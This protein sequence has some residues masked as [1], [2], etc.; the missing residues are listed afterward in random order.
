MILYLRTD[1]CTD[2]LLIGGSIG[3]TM[4]VVRELVLQNGVFVCSSA[5]KQ[6]FKKNN[7][8]FKALKI[9]PVFSVMR[10]KF[11][12]LRWRLDSFF[13]SFFFFFQILPIF[14]EHKFKFIYQ[15]YSILNF[16][17]VLLSKYKKT[18]L[19]LEYNGSEAY[20]FDIVGHDVWYR[21][22]FAFK[23]L[24]YWV[25]DLNLKY[26]YQIVAVSQALKDDLVLRGITPAKI[27]V[28]PNGVE[29]HIFSGVKLMKKRI[30]IREKYNLEKSFVFGFIGTF[31]HWHGIPMLE[32]I[33]PII[34]EKYPQIKFLLIGDGSLR[35]SL[36]QAVKQYI[37]VG[38]VILTGKVD[39]HLAPEYLSACDAF[40]CPTQPNADGTR[41]FGSPTKLFEYM[42]MAK[43]VIASDLEQ[44]AEVLTPAIKVSKKSCVAN[45]SIKNQKGLL[46]SPLDVQK[47]V[48]ACELCLHMSEDQ[49]EKLG[50]NAR[51]TILQKYTWKKHVERILERV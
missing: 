27:L 30:T 31:G 3:H 11:N 33:I 42:S 44:L 13:S 19:I 8:N 32:K 21:R 47:F 16:T 34:C 35:N 49:R 12:Y 18:P 4:G 7:I 43:P 14:K 20:W 38:Q 40:L 29:E 10:W 39:Q 22:W 28:N 17:G 15:R 37:D 5:M 48:K 2:S 25:E 9:W 50:E 1:L 26:A 46:V 41:F 24:S 45:L 36:E 51:A 6:V 23:R